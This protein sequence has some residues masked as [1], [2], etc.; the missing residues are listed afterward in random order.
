MKIKLKRNRKTTRN[1]NPRMPAA[2]GSLK[3][4]PAGGKGKPPNRFQKGNPGRQ[5]GTKNAIPTSV[6]ASLRA[7]MEEVAASETK[8]VRGALMTGLRGGPR[9]AHH[10]VKLMAEY[11]DGKPMDT[12]AI[13][14][15]D[16]NELT[17]AHARL[18]RKIELLV[19]AIQLRQKKEADDAAV[20]VGP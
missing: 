17:Q 19:K 20:P 5:K 1:G 13:Q 2:H 14:R 15:F 16:E 3:T 18:D 11:V 7:V 6:K 4:H 12:L 8:T 9:D 10:Y